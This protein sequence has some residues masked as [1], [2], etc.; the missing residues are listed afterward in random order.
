MWKHLTFLILFILINFAASQAAG[1]AASWSKVVDVQ[2]IDDAYRVMFLED[3]SVLVAGSAN[4]DGY[5]MKLDSLG[6]VVWSRLYG[7]SDWDEIRGMTPILQGYGYLLVGFTRSYSASGDNDVY[8]VEVN[9]EGAE[10]N[11][12]NYGTPGLF[13]SGYDIEPTSDGGYIIVG[14]HQVNFSDDWDIYL[15]KLDD[16][17]YPEWTT[18]IGTPG[19]RERGYGIVETPD[20]GFLICGEIGQPYQQDD[21]YLLK[22]DANG[23]KLWD[24]V[25]GGIYDEEGFDIQITADGNFLIS[26]QTWSWGTFN[27]YADM[28]LLLVDALGNPVWPDTVATFGGPGGEDDSGHG[29]AITGDNQFAEVGCT[30]KFTGSFLA[31]LVKSDIAGNLLW[32][33]SFPHP[34]S[35][36]E[37]YFKA[38]DISN[39]NEYALAGSSLDD[40]FVVKTEADTTI[41][42][43]QPQTAPDDFNVSMTSPSEILDVLANDFDPDGD[44]L[45]I[46]WV[47][48]PPNFPGTVRI[49]NHKQ[50]EFIPNT[51]SNEYLHFTYTVTDSMGGFRKEWVFVYVYNPIYIKSPVTARTPE[52]FRAY[53]NPFNAGTTFTFSLSHPSRVQLTIYSLTGQIMRT[54]IRQKMPPGKHHFYW[55]GKDDHNRLLASGMYLAQLKAGSTV[56]T[57]KVILLK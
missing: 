13:E 31:W 34:G 26:G 8:V 25:Y 35:S 14:D 51:N 36:A 11:S 54:V 24:R 32:E 9:R 44:S 18:I 15:I 4:T 33:T 47:T 37:T 12:W 45:F 53:P 38:I 55:D 41:H 19:V 39:R 3:G 56:S 43:H 28:F 21:V 57:I 27:G 17:F 49:V 10:Y 16:L 30:Q 29:V 7:G 5:L 23:Q 48:L 46:Q 40:V 1:P 20:G 42:N 6:N 2:G 52:L 22:V 50:L